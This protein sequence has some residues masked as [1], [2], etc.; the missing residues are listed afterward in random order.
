MQNKKYADTYLPEF[1]RRGK[2]GIAIIAGYFSGRYL[3]ELNEQY[4]SAL[5][6]GGFTLGL[7][8][9]QGAF[10]IYGVMTNKRR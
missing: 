6:I 3:S 5:F 10:H 2:L 8:I 7:I 1:I 4:R 9:F